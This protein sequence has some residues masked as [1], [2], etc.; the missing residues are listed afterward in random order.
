MRG[1]RF[2]EF[3]GS[4]RLRAASGRTSSRRLVFS[5]ADAK[6]DVADGF[7]AEALFELSQD[8]ELGD[9]FELVVQSRLEHAHVEN[10]FAQ[11]R[12]AQSARRFPV[13]L[14]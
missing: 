12:L 13:F 5:S 14:C 4:F 1:A 8:F 10:A 2:L 11:T 3:F 6:A 9:L 7:C